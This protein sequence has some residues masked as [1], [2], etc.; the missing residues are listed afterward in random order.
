MKCF[1]IFTLVCCVISTSIWAAPP[2]KAD[3]SKK[4]DPSKKG[5]VDEPNATVTTGTTYLLGK[6]FGPVG[7]VFSAGVMHA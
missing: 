1:V 5:D 2:K 6:F 3:A 7:A 4:P